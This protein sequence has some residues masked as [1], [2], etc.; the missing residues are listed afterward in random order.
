MFSFPGLPNPKK[1]DFCDHSH[2]LIPEHVHEPSS[3]NVPFD[4]NS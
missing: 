3:T 4:K 2:I 1:R